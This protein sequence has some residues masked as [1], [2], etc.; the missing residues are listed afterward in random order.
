[1]T[2]ESTGRKLMCLYL[3]SSVS[4]F[5]NRSDN[6]VFPVIRGSISTLKKQPFTFPTTWIKRDITR[7]MRYCV[8]KLTVMFCILLMFHH[9]H[10]FGFSRRFW[11]FCTR[12]CCYESYLRH[13][14]QVRFILEA[15]PTD[16]VHP[17]LLWWDVTS[18]CSVS[19]VTRP[20]PHIQ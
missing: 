2:F 16:L 14:S 15:P 9:V 17:N 19:D 8:F 1:M 5:K 11:C 12:W 10:W 6:G 4:R 3:A 20:R 7:N 13:F 18:Y